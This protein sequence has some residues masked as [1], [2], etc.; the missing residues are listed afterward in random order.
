M[1][2]SKDKEVEIKLEILSIIANNEGFESPKRLATH[3]DKNVRLLRWTRI[4][5]KILD[6]FLK[7][8]D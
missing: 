4:S 1:E 5:E 6:V 7:K 2:I 8:I 3:N